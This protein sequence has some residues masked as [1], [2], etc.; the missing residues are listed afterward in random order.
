[1]ATHSNSL[2]WEIPWTEEPVRLQSMELQ[3]VYLCHYWKSG[4]RRYITEESLSFKSTLGKI[5][6]GYENKRSSWR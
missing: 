5:I 4:D 6:T 1:M 3:T 2:A